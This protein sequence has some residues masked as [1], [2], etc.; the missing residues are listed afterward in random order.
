M[1]AIIVLLTLIFVFLLVLSA[2]GFLAWQKLSIFLTY[3]TMYDSAEYQKAVTTPKITHPYI[4]PS[5]TEQK[6]RHV[7]NVPDLVDITEVPFEDGYAAIVAA[8]EAT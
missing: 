7:T 6:G 3:N 2:A 8:G 4:P 5:K 1:T